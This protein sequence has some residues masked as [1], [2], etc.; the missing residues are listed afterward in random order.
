MVEIKDVV[1]NVN[2]R[3]G[4]ASDE[5]ERSIMFTPPHIGVSG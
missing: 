1:V 3:G 2:G 5:G 4:R